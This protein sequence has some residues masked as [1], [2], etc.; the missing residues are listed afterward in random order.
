MLEPFDYEF[1]NTYDGRRS[2]SG[3]VENDH[4]TWY[5]FRCLYQRALS[6]V[7]FT[8]PDG[9]NKNYFKNVLFGM[10]FIGIIPTAEYGII[11]Q[12]CNVSGYGLYLQ[13][14]RVLVAQ[15]LVNFE[16]Q[17]GENCEIIRLTPDY[18]GICDIVEHYAVLLAKLH[19]SITVS[20]I[21]SR[22]GLLAFAKNKSAAETLKVVAE[23]LSSGE[24]LVVVDKILK[25]TDDLDGKTEPI[26]TQAFDAAH[27]YVTDK[28]LE[29]YQTLL[30]NFDAEIGIPTID[31][32]KERRIEQE[33]NTMITDNCARVK[34]WKTALT[35][36]IDDVKKVFP[37]LDISFEFTLNK[38]GE[39]YVN[40]GETNDDRVV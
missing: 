16:G 25:E 12:I 40:N 8:L 2:P 3:T 23:K 15:P 21:N 36:S 19:T 20:L 11:P 38:G 32:K 5:Y 14:T 33:I 10:G 4:T 27:N 22:L 9:W 35:E 24:P 1:I 6:V 26:F 39:T 17:R 28:L 18:R 13:P 31:D 30:K 29:D 37:E 34:T 7:D